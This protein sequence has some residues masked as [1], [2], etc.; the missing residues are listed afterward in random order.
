MPDN[1]SDDEWMPPRKE[2][3]KPKNHALLAAKAKMA[4]N[5]GKIVIRCDKCGKKYTDKQQL[6]DHKKSH[7]S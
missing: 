4:H 7:G 3:P 5:K 1:S 2:K 6:K